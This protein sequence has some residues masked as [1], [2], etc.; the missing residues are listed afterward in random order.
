MRKIIMAVTSIMLKS[1]LNMDSHP[2]KNEVFPIDTLTMP[3]NNENPK[4][5]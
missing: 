5:T 2:G 1:E 4:L 3:L